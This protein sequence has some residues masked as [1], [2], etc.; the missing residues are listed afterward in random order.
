ME[1][2]L[3]I[4]F[5]GIHNASFRLVQALPGNRYFLTNSFS[6]LKKDMDVLD[7]SCRC[8]IIFGVDKNL[9]DAV[10]IEKTARCENE[11]K[12]Y[13]LLDLE[14]IS[15]S[16]AAADVKNSIS[17]NPTQYLCN[18]AYYYAL[19]KFRGKAVL[20]H[21]PTIKYADDAFI[22]RIKRAFSSSLETEN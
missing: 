10:R 9:K 3:Y 22:Q 20:I 8:A 17:D 1:N 12:L 18:E 2:I 19:Q 7:S 15:E 14:R 11:I 4:G 5:K 21:I 6:R 13:S 16:L